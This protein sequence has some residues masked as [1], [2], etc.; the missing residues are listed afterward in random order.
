M[1]WKCVYEMQWFAVD[2]SGAVQ[3]GYSRVSDKWAATDDSIV[4]KSTQETRMFCHLLLYIQFV[5]WQ[6]WLCSSTSII[7]IIIIIIIIWCLL[8]HPLK[9]AV[10]S[11]QCWVASC[12]LAPHLCTILLPSLNQ[13]TVRPFNFS[14]VVD[15]WAVPISVTSFLNSFLSQSHVTSALSFAIFRQCLK[16]F[17]FCCSYPDLLIWLARCYCYIT[18]FLDLVIIFV[19]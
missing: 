14:T 18:L 3:T 11:D 8:H 13:L 1:N 12:T 16:T 7:I 6:F 9:H 5:D 2:V 19:I 15:K 17:V 4:Q 10:A